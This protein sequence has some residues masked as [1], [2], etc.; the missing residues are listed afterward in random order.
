MLLI[1][2]G[3]PAIAQTVRSDN[4]TGTVVTNS[5]PFTITE[6][7]IRPSNTGATL[8]HSFENFSPATSQVIFNLQDSQ[9]AID[10]QAVTAII[11]RVTGNS[12]SFINGELTV[13]QESNTPVPDLFLINPQGILFGESAKLSLPGSFLASTADSILFTNG[14]TFSATNPGVAPL[15]T[16][17]AP[18]SLQ[19]GGG[20]S[21]GITLTGN[22]HAIATSNP[23][24][25]PYVSSSNSANSGLSVAPG[26]SLRLIGGSINLEGGVLSAPGG[27]IGIGSVQAGVVS[28][29][30][31]TLNYQDVERFGDI[32]LTERSLVA[33][34]GAIAHLLINRH[35]QMKHRH[36][37]R[38]LIV[39][40]VGI[41]QL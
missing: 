38:R 23:I 36:G 33:V 13:L 25:R 20:Q 22:G 18:I 27:S 7:T 2:V 10:T 12:A 19:F 6:G 29:Q 32:A 17:S 28:L 5:A 35:R 4:T 3:S 8:F 14:N 21:N 39:H 24:F 37:L 40:Y 30:E 1:S 26:A 34:G 41:T 9:N 15:L 16:V 11:G 31:P